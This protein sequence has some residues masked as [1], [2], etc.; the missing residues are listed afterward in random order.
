MKVGIMQPYFLPYI[1]YWQL[2]NAVDKYVVYDD[3]NFIKGGWV[4]RNR[5]LSNCN[6]VFINLLLSK[7]SPN[8]LINE[9]YIINGDREQKKMLKQIDQMY[10]KADYFKDVFPLVEKIVNYEEKNLALY[11]YYSILE[12]AKFLDMDTEFV[13]SSELEKDN[14]LKAQARV[15]DIVK[16]VGGHKYINA[17]GGV[18]L[19]DKSKFDKNGIELSF[20]KTNIDEYLQF[21]GEFVG[22]LSIIDVLMFNGKDKTKEMLNDFALV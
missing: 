6:A 13:L 9:I 20:L 22:G 3:V 16:T 12:I 1:G 5:V 15:I 18:E 7:A 17:I 2:M 10:R 14:Q 8:L 21:G 4:N 11:L 19:Y